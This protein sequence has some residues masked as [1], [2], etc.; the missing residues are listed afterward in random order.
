MG[1]LW[2][3]CKSDT[4]EEE[5]MDLE[6]MYQPIT[7]KLWQVDQKIRSQIKEILEGLGF[8]SKNRIYMGRVLGYIFKTSG[9]LLRPA[10][11]IL[12]ARSVNDRSMRNYEPLIKLAASVEFL[13]SASL[14]H[15]DII[16]ESVFRRNNPTLA[17][18]FDTKVAVLTGDILYAQ[19]VNILVN[20]TVTPVQQ[21]RLLNIFCGIAKEMC[22][23]E[24][25]E[26]KMRGNAQSL[27]FSSFDDYYQIIKSKTASLMAASCQGGAIV[28]GADEEVEKSLTDYGLNLGLMYQLVDDY[29][30]GDAVF[31]TKAE[32]FEIIGEFALRS[33]QS[34]STLKESPFKESLLSLSEY[35]FNRVP[36]TA[37]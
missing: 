3:R 4:S 22:S 28:A 35:V 11:V 23:G 7:D 6:S 25:L 10:L 8:D 17:S 26:E 15:D 19:F 37:H 9:K 5:T 12:S 30:D 2:E 34:L 20:L 33:K 14:I 18:R 16:D 27:S 31:G 24:I 21:K 36:V 29:L 13:H 32:V 1:I